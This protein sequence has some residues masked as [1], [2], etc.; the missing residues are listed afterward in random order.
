MGMRLASHTSDGPQ[1]SLVRLLAFT[2]Q[3]RVDARNS[4]VVIEHR[5]NHVDLQQKYA[6]VSNNLYYRTSDMIVIRVGG[7]NAALISLQTDNGRLSKL[8]E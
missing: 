7:W 5:V 3:Q 2:I 4:N 1:Q 6:T 8:T